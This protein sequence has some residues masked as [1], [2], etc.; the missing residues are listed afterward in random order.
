MLQHSITLS[1]LQ[2]VAEFLSNHPLSVTDDLS[3]QEWRR[4][5]EAEWRLLASEVFTREEEIY[6]ASL[7]ATFL[8]AYTNL[9]SLVATRKCDWSLQDRLAGME[10]LLAAPQIEQ[11]TEAWY[12]D[13]LGL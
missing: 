8:S 4:C 1:M 10:R 13:A 11:R 9:A 3:V 12:L 6:G 2:N 5:C 7:L